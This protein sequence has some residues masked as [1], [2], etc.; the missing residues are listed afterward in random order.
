MRVLTISHNHSSLHP[1][2]V[3]VFAESLHRF[4][5]TLK[6]KGKGKVES[7]LLAA[8]DP[9]LSVKLA[10]TSIQS[11]V[12]DK[13]VFFYRSP[14]FDPFQQ[15]RYSME[16]L[17]YELKWLIEDIQPDVYHIHHLNHFGVELLA[18]IRKLQPDAK[19]VM[20]IHDYYLICPNDG[21]LYTTGGVRCLREEPS[22]CLNCFPKL[23]IAHFKTRKR[24]IEMH[25]DLVDQFVSP[26]EFL[27]DRFVEWGIPKKK[28]QIIRNGLD[29]KAPANSS[30]P[31]NTNFAIFGNLRKTKGTL[32]AL[33]AFNQAAQRTDKDIRLDVYGEALYQPDSF[34]EAVEELEKQSEGRIRLHGGYQQEDLAPALKKSGWVLAP[35]IWWENAPLVIEE[36]FTF[37]RPVICSDIGGMKEAVRHGVDGL[38]VRAGDVNEWTDAI[39]KSV[40]DEALWEKLSSKIRAGR[41]VQDAGNEYH[42]LFQSLGA[43]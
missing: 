11:S 2:G 22:A 36:A 25:L 26:S 19:I 8:L 3:E 4:Y 5:K 42:S 35:S 12:N 23:N 39:L 37:G 16:S 41:T 31:K 43:K 7:Y 15:S 10:G 18:L 9:G 13:T 29:L 38:H 40:E 32:V 33:E 28:I 17:V 6:G 1:G 27:R 14:G 24:F 20:T 21:L 30:Q 34:K